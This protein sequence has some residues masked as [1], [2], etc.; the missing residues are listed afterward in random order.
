MD[1]SVDMTKNNLTRIIGWDAHI[2]LT[3]TLKE[4]GKEAYDSILK[5]IDMIR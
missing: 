3:E 2:S 1:F 5:D 4:A